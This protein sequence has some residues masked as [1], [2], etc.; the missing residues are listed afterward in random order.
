[1]IKRKDLTD[2]KIFAWLYFS[3][4]DIN[5]GI[6]EVLLKENEHL[7]MEGIKTEDCLDVPPSEI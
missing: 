1:M 7:E 4:L 3:Y 5:L 2:Q 6:L